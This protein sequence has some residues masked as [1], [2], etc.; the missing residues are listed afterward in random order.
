MSFF[1]REEELKQA[2]QLEY[3]RQLKEE[4]EEKLE[5]EEA[6]KEEPDIHKE[7]Q[8]EEASGEGDVEAGVSGVADKT[9]ESDDREAARKADGELLEKIVEE[10]ENLLAGKKDHVQSAAS[11]G[12]AG[13]LSQSSLVT[14]TSVEPGTAL[15]SLLPRKGLETQEFLDN[16]KKAIDQLKSLQSQAVSL[17]GLEPALI[18]INKTIDGKDGQLKII[19]HEKKNSPLL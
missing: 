8:S 11:I 14:V 4:E 3:E 10:D 6:P 12:G 9:S 2:R 17:T 1:Q 13:N 18:E 15:P 16:V 5:S 19:F 7:Q